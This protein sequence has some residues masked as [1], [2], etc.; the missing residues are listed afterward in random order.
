MFERDPDNAAQRQTFTRRALWIGGAQVGALS[1]IGGRLWHLQVE[2]QNRYGLLADENRVSVQML[3]PE[4]GRILDRFGLV[5]AS[6]QESYRAVLLPALA[7]DARTVLAR[8]ARVVPLSPEDL[9]KLTVRARRQSANTPMIVAQDLTF[10][11]IAAINLQ[12]PD[13]PGIS[14]EAA[15]KRRYVQGRAVGHVVGYIGANERIAMDDDPVLRLPGMRTGKAGVERGQ[16]DSLR[17]KAG[18][19]QSEVDSR[20]RIVRHLDRVEPV[21]GRDV[22]LTIDTVL[23]A[24]VVQKLAAFRRAASV[25]IDVNSG[26]VIVLASVPTFDPNDIVQGTSVRAWDRLQAQ[27]D[28]PMNSRAIRGVYPP[29]STFKMVT[30]LAGLEAGVIDLKE[31]IACDGRFDYFDQTFRCWKRTGHGSCDFHRAMRESCDC[32]FYEVAR[33]TGIDALAAMARKLG[34]GQTYDCG[35]ANLKRGLIPDPDWKRGRFNK[36]WTGGETILAG[37]GQGYVLT[38]PLQLAVMTARFATGMAVTPTFVRPGETGM[39]RTMPAP[40]PGRPEWHSAIRRAMAAVVNEDGGTGSKA[41][42]ESGTYLV[43]GKTGTSQVSRFSSET[44][45]LDLRWELRDHA[46]FVS[47]APVIKP[48]YAIATIVEHGGG[49]GSTAAPLSRDILDLVMERDPT[50]RP[51]WSAAPAAGGSDSGRRAEQSARPKG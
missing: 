3:A 51:A 34:L 40:I 47:Y 44:A 36:P 33:R 6:N 9:D 31:K 39:T 29:G 23:Q 45:Q 38:T 11:Q 20:G 17:G 14:T 10:E 22:V 2:E 7:R 37:I 35:L 24:Q 50:A 19:V 49:G 30:G 28:D 25:V 32:Y 13:L 15:P 21:P 26:E 1:L 41:Q 8:F 27:L 12:A 48:R 5:L 4:R 18:I 46:L 43:A 16:E 42:P